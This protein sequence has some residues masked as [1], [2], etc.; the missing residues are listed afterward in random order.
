MRGEGGHIEILGIFLKV[1]DTVD[2]MNTILP[3]QGEVG[4]SALKRENLD[5]KIQRCQD[6]NAIAHHV[7]IRNHL[8]LVHDH[9]GDVRKLSRPQEMMKKTNSNA[10][11]V[12]DPDQW[13][14]LQIRRMKLE[15]RS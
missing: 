2:Q 5:K 9:R 3:D 6:I 13:K 11:H 7:E 14:I 15:M 10:E 1:G 12:Q 8:A 4:V